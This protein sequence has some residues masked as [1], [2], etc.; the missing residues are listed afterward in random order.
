MPSPPSTPAPSSASESASDVVRW[1]AFSC[2]LV[3]VVLL[4]YGTSFG[5]AAGTAVGLAA[6]TAACRVLLRRSERAAEE[7][8]R[9]TAPHR[10]G[11][12]SRPGA[13]A[14]RGGRHSAGCTPR[15]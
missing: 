9:R 2:A 8:G 5:G 4:V 10:A 15:D 3:P 11:R 7:D 12:H 6:V 14:H 1:A 13:G